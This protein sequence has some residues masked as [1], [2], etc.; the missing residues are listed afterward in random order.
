MSQPDITPRDALL[1]LG[2]STGEAIEQV[3]E[4][5]APG[6][7]DRG[8]VS[9]IAEGTSPFASLSPGAVASS[10][11]YVDGVTGANV[12]V[13]TALGAR[14]LAEAMGAAMAEGETELS[15][16][17]LSAVA[18]AANQMMAAAAGAIGNVLGQ[19]IDI[20]PPDTRVIDDPSAATKIYGT[21][22]HATSTTF[23]VA[24]ESCRLI[25]LVPS[26]FVVRMVRAI[27]ELGD[28]A[29]RAPRRPLGAAGGGL[30]FGLH[31][32]IGETKLRVW[33]ELGRMRMPLG[34]ALALPIGAVVDL[35]QDADA[36]VDLYVNGVRFARGHLVVSAGQ[37]AI[38]VD[39]L[40]KTGTLERSGVR[41]SGS[42]AQPYQFPQVR[43]QRSR[44]GVIRT[45]T[46]RST[47]VMAR[48]LVVD[49]A[50]FMRK[51]VSDAL[52]SGGHEVVGEACNGSEAIQ[53]YQELQPELTTLDITMPE[54]D[55][56]A[57]LAEIIAI[58]PSARV[59]M[60]SALGQEGKVIESIKLGA[61]D[62]VVKPFQP[63]R[64]L[65]AVGKARLAPPISPAQDAPA[66][67]RQVPLK[68][69]HPL[70]DDWVDSSL[71][72]FP[73]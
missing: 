44:H 12:F 20:S 58:N 11:S 8:E 36:P 32:V 73:R 72:V 26:A 64:L 24:G 65:E 25:Q 59:L 29:P 60:C 14:K 54:K 53:R 48:V 1:R 19:Q 2:R 4:T 13:T 33:A 30:G 39:E 18:E 46:R 35:D 57:T 51:V 49:D 42:E 22:P 15:E 16:L 34:R 55:G 45:R 10:V 68:R 37:W 71:G 56:L 6:A 61:K 9:V 23:M 28:V 3:L 66:R 17:Q 47:D 50:A 62:F 27:D 38:C 70:A 43:L 21:A 41:R 69:W 40:V 63:T 31:D 52:A 7:V 5:F 67:R